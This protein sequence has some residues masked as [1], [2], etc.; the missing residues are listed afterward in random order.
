MKRRENEQEQFEALISAYGGYIHAIIARVANGRVQREDIEE[1]AADVLVAVW[2]ARAHVD[3]SADGARAY[4]AAA[5]RNRAIS[6][7]QKV[8][9]AAFLPLEEDILEGFSDDP[10]TEHE[11]RELAA[12]INEAV[13]ALPPPDPEIFV[14]RYYFGDG[15]S[16]IA[17]ALGLTERAVE[18]RIYRGKKQLRA[19][20]EGRL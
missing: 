10:P 11:K 6:L 14:R 5:A 13:H 9:R 17:Q 19:Y 16:A 1:C 20:L 8:S 12:I 15:L 7:V 4:I 18:G 3:I 2:N